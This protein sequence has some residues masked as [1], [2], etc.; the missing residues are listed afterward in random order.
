MKTFAT[1]I[2]FYNKQGKNTPSPPK[3]IFS[4]IDNIY[5]V[6]SEWSAHGRNAQTTNDLTK[7]GWEALLNGMLQILQWVAK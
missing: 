5:T 4:Y 6:T 3:Y 1:L 2:N 7:E